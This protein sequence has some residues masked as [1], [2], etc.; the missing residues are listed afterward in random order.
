MNI[1]IISPSAEPGAIIG[2]ARGTP[3]RRY[4]FHLMQTVRGEIKTKIIANPRSAG[5][6]TGKNWAGIETLLKERLGNF[7]AEF[8]QG[9]RDATN[10]ARR[11]LHDGYELVACVGGDG[12]INE[13]INGFFEDG[14]P[15]NPSA[16][17]GVLSAGTGCDFIKTLGIPRDLA[18]CADIIATGVASPL[19]I[20][21]IVCEGHDGNPVEIYFINIADFGIGGESVRIVNNSH[22]ILKG[23]AAFLWS[24]IKSG[25]T[26]KNK[27]VVLTID[28]VEQPVQKIKNVIIAN[29]QYFAGGMRIAK[30]ADPTDGLFDLI[31]LGNIGF[32]GGAL[33]LTRLYSGDFIGRPKVQRLHIRSL[34]AASAEKVFLDVDGEQ[35]GSLPATFDI[36]PA[37]INVMLPRPAADQ[38]LLPPSSSG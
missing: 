18:L 35:P 15:V 16:T 5:G 7:D 24:I 25:V 3:K 17:F 8:T 10:I 32:I 11:A 20:G 22:K 19:D 37:A 34:Q 13:T 12:S 28:G 9:P 2:R 31:I 21:R 26:Y 1:V 4:C 30:D 27:P 14:K 36:L 6:R 38:D 29:C 23:Y 33:M